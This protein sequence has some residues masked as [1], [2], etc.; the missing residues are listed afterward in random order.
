[1]KHPYRPYPFLIPPPRCQVSCQGYVG[2]ASTHD[3]AIQASVTVVTVFHH[4]RLA[5]KNR[6]LSLHAMYGVETWACRAARTLPANFQLPVWYLTQRHCKSCVFWVSWMGLLW[7]LNVQSPW[8]SEIVRD[9]RSV[10]QPCKILQRMQQVEIQRFF[11]HL[12]P[13]IFCFT[14][15]RA[16]GDWSNPATLDNLGLVLPE[17]IGPQVMVVKAGSLKFSKSVWE[18]F[19]ALEISLDNGK[20]QPKLP[21]IPLAWYKILTTH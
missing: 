21:A 5:T 19:V 9:S 15:R 16:R 2:W 18:F 3:I 11:F 17:D 14:H 1:M 4:P 7:N 8:E 10:G 20:L 13:A 6:S 12:H